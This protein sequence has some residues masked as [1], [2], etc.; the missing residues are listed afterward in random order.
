MSHREIEVEFEDFTADR[1]LRHILYY[2]RRIAS[3]FQPRSSTLTFVPPKGAAMPQTVHVND[4]P[5]SYLYQEFS[6]PNGTGIPVPPTGSV[7]YASDT[8]AVATIDPNTG[9]LAY[10]SAG[11]ATISA[12]DG[13]N[14]P[15]SDVLTVS[16]AAAASSTLTFVPPPASAVT[17]AAARVKK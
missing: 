16:A 7:Q 2:V 3:V 9:Q 1:L 14:L 11:T 5:G 12:S 10:V 15:A 8:P 13:G 4:V 6:G 17:A